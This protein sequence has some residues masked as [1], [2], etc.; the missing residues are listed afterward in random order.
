MYTI[1][2]LIQSRGSDSLAG[3][4]GADSLGFN[5]GY[6]DTVSKIY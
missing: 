2:P 6:G 4:V 5:C 1:A 3:L